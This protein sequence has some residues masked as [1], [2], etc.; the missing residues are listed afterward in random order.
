MIRD[1][2]KALKMDVRKA[3]RRATKKD[4]RKDVKR[5]MRK[6]LKRGDIVKFLNHG[7]LRVRGA[8]NAE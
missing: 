7:F 3:M 8:P 6:V 1:M 4:T 5:G 2:N